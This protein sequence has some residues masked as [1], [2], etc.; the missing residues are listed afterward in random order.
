MRPDTQDLMLHPFLMPCMFDPVNS[1]LPLRLNRLEM[2][3]SKLRNELADLCDELMKSAKSSQQKIEA[4]RVINAARESLHD[5]ME[6][7]I[8]SAEIAAKKDVIDRGFVRYSMILHDHV[9]KTLTMLK[10]DENE[11]DVDEDEIDEEEKKRSLEKKV[12]GKDVIE[13]SRQALLKT[14]AMSTQNLDPESVTSATSI[15]EVVDVW[16]VDVYK[17]EYMK[18][19]D[20]VKNSVVKHLNPTA[21]N[22]E[23]VFELLRRRGDDE[24]TF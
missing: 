8:K 10:D 4:R 24:G 20:V 6:Q 19:A 5:S 13:E 18:V 9:S 15:S 11:D 3:H 22:Q 21:A 17:S 2:M 1:K 16:L 23:I 7:S 14:R 12:S